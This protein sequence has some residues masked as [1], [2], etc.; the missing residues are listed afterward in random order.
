MEVPM[1]SC[2]MVPTV[3]PQPRSVP[4]PY[5]APLVSAIDK[6]EKVLLQ[7]KLDFFFHIT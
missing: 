5:E 2:I 4:M 1:S 6:Y 3:S 7:R